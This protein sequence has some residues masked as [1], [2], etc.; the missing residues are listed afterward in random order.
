MGTMMSKLEAELNKRINGYKMIPKST[1]LH[2][3]GEFNIAIHTMNKALWM[4]QIYEVAYR[5][6]SFAIKAPCYTYALC[7]T[8]LK[9]ANYTEKSHRDLMQSFHISSCEKW[10]SVLATALYNLGCDGMTYNKNE[11][12]I[13]FPQKSLTQTVSKA[14]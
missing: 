1:V 13:C 11:E 6:K 3:F 4:S 5:Y 14:I 9:M 7:S 10:N 12:F 2:H 8:E